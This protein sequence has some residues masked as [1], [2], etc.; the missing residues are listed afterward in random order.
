MARQKGTA[1]F[2]GTIEPLAGGPIDARTVVPTKTD[3]TASTSFPYYYEGMQVYVASEKARYTLKGDDPTVLSNWEKEGASVDVTVYR[4]GGSL[5]FANLPTLSESVLGYVYNLLDDFTT[6]SDFVEGAG[7]DF[8]AGTNVA[9][10]ATG[11]AENPVYKF[12][13]SGGYVDLSEYQKKIQFAA[14]PTPDVNYAD[15]IVQYIG[16]TIENVY[17]NG[18]FYKCVESEETPGTYNWVLFDVGDYVKK[19]GDTMT[20]ALTINPSLTVGARAANKTNGLLSGAVGSFNE[21]SGSSSFAVGANNVASGNASQAEGSYSTASGLA[22]HAEGLNT[23]AIGDYSHAEGSNSKVEGSAAHAEGSSTE[24]SGNYS[25]AEGSTTKATYEAAHAEGYQSIASKQAAHAE[26]HTT[27]A[28]GNYSHSEGY[29]TTASDAAAHAEGWNTTASGGNGSHAEGYSTTASGNSAHSEGRYTKATG[30]YSHASGSGTVAGYSDQF[31]VGSY[32]EN[33]QDSAFEIGNGSADNT[34]RNA[35]EVTKTGDLKAAG[36]LSDANGN[37]RVQYTT[38]PAPASTL[39]NAIVQFIGTTTATY[40]NGYFYKCVEDADNPGTYIW[41]PESVQEGGSGS[42][43]TEITKADFDALSQS[44]KD[45]GQAYFIPDASIISGFTVMGNRFDKANIYTADERMIGSWMGKP[46]Y[47]RTFTFE[48]P[49]T[50]PNNSW[51]ATGISIENCE[52]I[53]DCKAYN[54]TGVFDAGCGY[55]SSQ[56]Q[57]EITR[58]DGAVNVHSFTIQYT[59]TTD[60][61]VNIGTGNDYSTDEQIIGTWID[62]KPLYQKTVAMTVPTATSGTASAATKLDISSWNTEN[63]ISMKG[64]VPNVWP[65]SIISGYLTFMTTLDG[66][67]INVYFDANTKEIVLQNHGVGSSD[68]GGKTAYITLYYTKT[69]D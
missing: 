15:A 45:N 64:F 25:H 37:V 12:D 68:A 29:Q 58:Y 24:A 39:E 5:L 9:V 57:L 67:W 43:I 49:V 44:D 10:V 34:R 61:T 13:A 47:Q 2:S 26:G 17:T 6:T 30:Y 53:I 36:T 1:N 51:Y 48:N 19:S 18:R 31:V 54:L 21:A 16:E 42:E 3:L 52:R 22:A 7:L 65:H 62:S 38:M 63:V 46:L 28:S 40:T 60:A 56:I 27:T 35:L 59:K 66:F 20:G 11:T 23:K 8:P 14:M 32:N 4:P 33:K 55:V 41:Q 50:V 69:T